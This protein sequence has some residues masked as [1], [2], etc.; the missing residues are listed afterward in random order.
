MEGPN[1]AQFLHAQLTSDIAGMQPGQTQYSG[2]CTPQ[3]RLLALFL[4]WRSG[5]RFALQLPGELRESIQMR[6]AKYVLRAQVKLTD[7]TPAHRV[8]GLVGARTA[9]ALEDAVGSSLPAA[10][11]DLVMAGSVR[12]TRL[13]LDR[14]VVLADAGIASQMHESLAAAAQEVS[15]DDW[16]RLD[17]EAGTP[18]ITAR[19]REAFVPQ[20]V[21][22]DLLG[23][24]SYNKGCYPGQ[25]IV[26]RMHYLG[27]LKQRMYRAHVAADQRPMAGDPLYS[28]EFGA[29][30][31]CG[32]IVTA[33]PAPGGG[34]DALAVIQISS[35]S[36]G[37]AVHWQTPAGPALVF[38]PLPY[39]LPG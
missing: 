28:A 35:V 33:A 27:R 11:H 26:A 29:D 3:G 10:P 15:A 14:Y 19:T 13:T 31:S 7:A 1:A 32:T 18:V 23:G 38:L 9:R 24:V 22:L 16:A 17:I 30:Q 4:V 25:E 5:E 2:Y 34:F 6:L 39:G 20:M 12:I 37:P 8:F 36:R 21:N